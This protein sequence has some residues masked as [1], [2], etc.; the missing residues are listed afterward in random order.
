M[1]TLLAN[2]ATVAKTHTYPLTAFD[3]RHSI[4]NERERNQEDYDKK[5]AKHR[6]R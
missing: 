6:N 5:L 3:E 2:P 4:T 1:P